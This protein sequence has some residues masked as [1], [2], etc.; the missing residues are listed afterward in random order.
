MLL[1]VYVQLAESDKFHRVINAMLL[2]EDLGEICSS[3]YY[4]LIFKVI[5]FGG[6]TPKQ[7]IAGLP[8]V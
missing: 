4:L 5:H 8:L 3:A 7:C 2:N 1:K 6:H